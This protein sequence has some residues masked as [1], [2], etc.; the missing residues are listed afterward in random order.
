M[1]AAAPAGP[2]AQSRRACRT[3]RAPEVAA[4]RTRRRRPT[5]F[6]A[7]APDAEAAARAGRLRLTGARGNGRR[8]SAARACAVTQTGVCALVREYRTLPSG[9]VRLRR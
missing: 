6:A 3:T 5:A 4:V 8:A 1:P 7:L 9:A 2:A